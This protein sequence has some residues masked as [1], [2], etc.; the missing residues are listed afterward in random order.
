MV[1]KS[2]KDKETANAHRQKDRTATEDA[3]LCAALK[4]FSSKG[5]ESATTRE[6]AVEAGCSE[7]LIHRYF[8]SKEGLLLAVFRYTKESNCEQQPVLPNALTVYDEIVQLLTAA[9]AHFRENNALGRIVVSRSIID[10]SFQKMLSAT[11]N[12]ADRL[13][14]IEQ[15]LAFHQEAGRVAPDANLLASAETI[16]AMCFHLGFMVQEVMRLPQPEISRL[17]TCYARVLADGIA[18]R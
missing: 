3:L 18:T 16:G 11:V 9:V 8:E 12:K 13:K 5:F 1:R 17:I 7:A 2:V 14:Q 4:I 10:P 6:I 15:R